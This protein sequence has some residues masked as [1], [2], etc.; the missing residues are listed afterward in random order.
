MSNSALT[1]VPAVL[2]TVGYL[3]PLLK[4]NSITL[5]GSK[6]VGDQLRTSFKPDSVMEFGFYIEPSISPYREFELALR[7]RRS[8]LAFLSIGRTPLVRLVV[9]DS[10]V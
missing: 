1:A 3:V 2:I 10:V 5:S 4:P 6:L 9:A 7:A 8:R